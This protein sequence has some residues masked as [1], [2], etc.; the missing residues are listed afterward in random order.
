MPLLQFEAF[1][2]FLTRNK[3]RTHFLDDWYDAQSSR[4]EF[5]KDVVITFDDGYLDN[6]VYLF[7]LLQKYQL[8]ATIFVNPGFVDPSFEPRDN[9][10]QVWSGDIDASKLEALGFL[11]WHE[12]C[13]MQKSGLV[14][15]QSHS[16]THDWLFSSD[17][18]VDIYVGQ[19]EYD[20]IAWILHPENKHGYITDASIAAQTPIGYPVFKSGRALGV[21]QF[22]PNGELVAFSIAQAQ[23]F[24][25]REDCLPSFQAIT[26]ALREFGDKHGFGEYET[27]VKQIERYWHE[28]SGSK[29]ILEEKLGKSVEYLCWPGGG[30][31]DISVRLSWE[32]GYKAST[33]ASWDIATI[34]D[35]TSIIKRIRRITLSHGI[36]CRGKCFL[37]L[38]RQFMGLSFLAKNGS[39][40][41]LWAL[42]L[43]KSYYYSREL[44]RVR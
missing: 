17:K 32:A 4:R 23:N 16:M 39:I 10:N 3:I 35:N 25:E 8:K 36:S 34:A 13:L 40:A 14:D 1:C 42:K 9:L 15:I 12:V 18:L 37:P 21:R 20:W 38:G 11:N 31:N 43:I 41:C 33:I 26:Y 30:Y 24:R 27:E 28:L 6:W 29:Q 7:P 19:D 2:H 22:F 5:R 44:F